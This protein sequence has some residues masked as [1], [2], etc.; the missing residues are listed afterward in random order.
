[1]FQECLT[2]LRSIVLQS[3]GITSPSSPD[4]GQHAAVQAL[5]SQI[6]PQTQAKPSVAASEENDSPPN[7]THQVKA[8]P[9]TKMG[10]VFMTP[11]PNSRISS[12]FG[13]LQDEEGSI[14]YEPS[15]DHK[16]SQCKDDSDSQYPQRD[17]NL[18]KIEQ[19]SREHERK[20]R[21]R[22]KHHRHKSHDTASTERGLNHTNVSPRHERNTA[23]CV[24]SRDND[25]NPPPPKG[26]WDAPLTSPANHSTT[27]PDQLR[28]QSVE[29]SSN[30]KSFLSPR[31]NLASCIE[32]SPQSD[33]SR[34]V[35][36]SRGMEGRGTEES[37]QSPPQAKVLSPR[38]EKQRQKLHSKQVELL[39]S[40]EEKER[41]VNEVNLLNLKVLEEGTK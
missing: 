17:P 27:S 8:S 19:R 7:K 1:M 28:V 20:R 5:S 3:L 2:V 35:P 22:H 15:F 12:G 26:A 41:L 33:E 18:I 9:R 24:Q 36:I 16:S 31:Q 37:V 40:K 10:H 23:A 29:R 34:N 39:K 11:S 38:A 25:S 32:I 14:N 6:S 13:S 4:S 30:N 21:K